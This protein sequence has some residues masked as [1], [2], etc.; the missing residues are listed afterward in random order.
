[1]ADTSVSYKCPHCGAPI[2]FKPEAQTVTCDYCG[3]KFD[4]AVLEGLYAK[5]EQLAAE[6]DA[7]RQAKWQTEKAGNEWSDEEAAR[8]KGYTCSSCGA[9]IVCDDN[10]MATECCYCGNPTL[11]PSRFSGMLRPDFIIPFKKT[12]DEAVAALKRFY[13]GHWLLPKAFTVNNR[14][15]DVQAMYV[16]FWLF[17]AKVTASASF[18]AE[19]DSYL[20]TEDERIVETRVYQCNRTGQLTFNRIPVD[21]SK[22]INDLYMESI[23]PFD[24]SQ[25]VPFNSAYFAG[26][27]AD[28]YDVDA[29]AAVPRAD[30]RLEKSSFDLLSNTVVNHQRRTLE[31]GFVH[32]DE[33]SVEYAMAPVWILTTRYQDKPYTFMMNGQTGRFVGSLPYDKVKSYWAFLIAMLVTLPVF[34]LI[35]HAIMGGKPWPI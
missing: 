30:S 28:K 24:Y 12:K 26:C 1:M 27:L 15:E 13:R 18:R 32:K 5:K 19:D 16:P 25:I 4:V 10:T 14:I 3:T 7:A 2:Q 34:Y 6:A 23:E 33:D 9:E 11:I 31:G 29:E 17:N 35:V 20:E 21:G 8:L 22:K